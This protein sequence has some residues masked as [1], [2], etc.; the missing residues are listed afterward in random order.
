MTTTP[1]NLLEELEPVVA[2]NLD[3]HLS[4]AQEWHPHDYVPWSQGRDFAMLGGEDQRAFEPGAAPR[5]AVV[6]ACVPLASEVCRIG[7]FTRL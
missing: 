5:T 2:E 7:V 3:R 4:M 1:P 6:S